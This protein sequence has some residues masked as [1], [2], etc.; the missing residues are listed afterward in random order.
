MFQCGESCYSSDQ[1]SCESGQLISSNATAGNSSS[2]SGEQ[3]YTELN[4]FS[5]PIQPAARRLAV[6][7]RRRD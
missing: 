1:F 6:L 2:S 4:V 3:R 5:L 7:R